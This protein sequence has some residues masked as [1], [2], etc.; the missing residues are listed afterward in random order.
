MTRDSGSKRERKFTDPAHRPLP[1][2]ATMLGPRSPF[3]PM[4]A[5]EHRRKTKR[6]PVRWKTAVVFEK[7]HAKP[8]LHTQ[9]VDLSSG[10][11]A[12]V[13]EHGDIAGATVTLLLAQPT[14]DGAA[15]PR[16]LKVRAE[17]VSCVETKQRS[18]YRH[19]LRFLRAPDDGLDAL[20]DLLRVAADAVHAAA[21]PAGA[22]PASP[23]PAGRLARLKEMAQ[24]KLAEPA[25][26]DPQEE[27]NE[28]ITSALFRAY[29]YLKALAEQLDVV[30]P[31]YP[32]GYTIVGLPE[33]TGLTWKSGRVDFRSREVGKDKKIWE[34]VSFNVL[35]SA[36]KKIKVQRES[37]ATERLQRALDDHRIR[38]HASEARNDRGAVKHTTF[39]IE[40]DVPVLV[41]FEGDFQ[42]GR[43]KMR[44]RD[45]E[46]WGSS[47]YMLYPEA[48]TE[49]ALEEFAGV[50]LGE[51]H[52]VGPLI[53]QGA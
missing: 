34:Q 25:K 49:A 10:G 40:C 26:V 23:A 3:T 8:T 50:L 29:E 28:K 22:A 7:P 37:P 18:G 45:V 11:A 9:T 19:G 52:K 16:M 12:I 13:S 17:V 38:Y 39:T 53:L 6:F 4:H 24:A 1:L 32:K 21:A 43:I 30:R 51:T 5:N 14:R 46:R 42:T 33:F 35:L 2:S 27:I 41:V 31:P 47:E 36:D 48:I 15:A 20:E 44:L